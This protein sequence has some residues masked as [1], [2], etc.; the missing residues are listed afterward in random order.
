VVFCGSREDAACV[1]ESIL[2]AWL[3]ERGL[4]LSEE[5]T[6][7]AHLTEGFDF[8]GFNVRL[9]ACPK[10]TRTGY[11]CLIRPSKKSVKAV[12][13]KLR[14]AWLELKGHSLNAVLGRL[15]P[16]IRGWANYFR[17][18]VASATFSKL[19]EWR[20]WRARRY[21]KHT[22][23]HQSQDWRVQR[24][25]GKL[26]Q[27]RKDRWVFGK[28]RPDEKGR[29]RYLLKF[30]WHKMVRHTLV[31]GSHSPDDPDLREYWWQRRKVN[32]NHLCPRDVDLANDQDWVCPICGVELINGEPLERHHIVARSDGG[33]EARAN[34]VLVHLY[35]HQQ[36]TAAW[37]KRRRRSG[38]ES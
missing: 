10:T 30:S 21:L 4:T 14:A 35:C 3:A 12:R 27:D 24:Y 23:P 13:Q 33:S 9:F 15:N 29:H 31:K 20:H 22:H 38:K 16:I 18:Q 6:R 25:F 2:P 11:K 32:V 17:T 5:K 7:I 37:R 1:K 36:E 26:N 8:L 19:D 28:T 34:R